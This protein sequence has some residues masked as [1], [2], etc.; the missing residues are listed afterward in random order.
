MRDDT[1]EQF[2]EENPFTDDVERETFAAEAVFALVGRWAVAALTVLL[3]LLGG[4]ALGTVAQVLGC[5]AAPGS[6]TA[7]P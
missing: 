7:P 1:A 5:H 4:L 2:V 6:C 3:L